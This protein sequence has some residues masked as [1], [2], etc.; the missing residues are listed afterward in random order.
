MPWLPWEWV[1][2]KSISTAPTADEDAGSQQDVEPDV[3]PESHSDAASQ[4][5]NLEE[6][7]AEILQGDL[8]A[9]F[10]DHC[11][12]SYEQ[13]CASTIPLVIGDAEGC[14]DL[15]QAAP[16]RYQI[17]SVLYGSLG[18]LIDA[19]ASA[20]ANGEAPEVG[21]S[22]F[23]HD[24]TILRVAVHAHNHSGEGFLAAV[25]RQFAKDHGADIL[26]L[27]QQDM[28]E[29]YD[30]FFLERAQMETDRS[31]RQESK[32]DEGE[33]KDGDSGST[34]GSTPDSSFFETAGKLL[35]SKL[36]T[37]I[38]ARTP[39]TDTASCG[40]ERQMRPLIVELP[41][42]QGIC[43]M[44]RFK[45]TL[46]NLQEAVKTANSPRLRVLVVGLDSWEIAVRSDVYRDSMECLLDDAPTQFGYYAP[47]GTTP[48]ESLL[49]MLGSNPLRPVLPLLP[50]HTKA[51]R[52]LFAKH[53]ANKRRAHNIRALQQ[54]IRSRASSCGDEKLLEPYS[55]WDL[56][57]ESQCFKIL[58]HSEL[59]PSTIELAAAAISTNVT[60]DHILKV[61]QGLGSLRDQIKPIQEEEKSKYS[62]LHPE[63]QKAIAEINQDLGKYQ[64]ESVLLDQLVS[65]D[66]VNQGWSAIEIEEDL[67]QAITQM[68]DLASS[69]PD[70]QAGILRHSRINGVLLYGPPGTG[71]TH[72]AR[73]LAHEY[74]AVMIHVS[75]AELENKY[76]GETEKAIKGLFNLAAMVYPSIIFIDEADSLFRKRQPDDYDWTRSRLNTLLAQTDGLIKNRRQPFLL[77]ATNHPGD[78]DEAILRR[79][80]S[81]LYIGLPSASAR[82]SM[83][84]IFLREEELDSELRLRDIAARTTGFTGSDLHTVCVQAAL[85]GQAEQRKHGGEQTKRVLKHAHFEEAL[86]RCGPTVSDS[87]MEAIRVFAEKFDPSAVSRLGSSR[88]SGSVGAAPSKHVP[89][90]RTRGISASDVP[91]VLKN[92]QPPTNGDGINGYEEWKTSEMYPYVTE[93]LCQKWWSGESG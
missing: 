72:L 19:K 61:F 48:D 52:S 3:E 25:L 9:W 15:S 64:W 71:K 74:G 14:D 6:E 24:A 69:N 77:I 63:A 1:K 54:K 65:P 2:P 53:G 76:V 43:A 89:P 70:Q 10:L 51:Q 59:K 40:S 60:I 11:I 29:L 88:K 87:A 33:G 46:T 56:P 90:K 12:Q 39:E 41:D 50:A 66:D 79:V 45:E 28:S 31:R 68:L 58:S 67:K 78:L 17:D 86:E 44:D 93:E 20:L 27:R 4:T 81:R 62:Q 34:T 38:E 35:F 37:A 85:I 83:L 32:D 49:S 22:T 5:T 75:A 55:S 80:P 16:G 47:Y 8:P 7:L 26:T 30:M 36:L 23:A 57:E 21:S 92:V 13:I 91:P 18:S 73:V 82:E 42:L 84:N